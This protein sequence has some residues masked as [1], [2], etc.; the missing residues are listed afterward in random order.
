MNEFF[1][2]HGE[3]RTTVLRTFSRRRGSTT[4]LRRILRVVGGSV[5]LG[6]VGFGIFSLVYVHSVSCEFEG[7]PC[8]ESEVLT[9]KQA[10]GKWMFSSYP[11]SVQGKKATVTREF[12]GILHV[13]LDRQET[14]MIVRTSLEGNDGAIVRRDGSLENTKISTDQTATGEAI[15]YDLDISTDS[16]GGRVGANRL[17]VYDALNDFGKKV[18]ITRVV[19]HSNDEIEIHTA[20][21]LT[22]VL[23]SERIA[24]QLRS[25]Q[26]IL[27]SPTIEGKPA[28]VDMRFTRPI[29][30]YL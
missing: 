5:L 24:D 29:L 11:T 20:R 7:N 21:D 9:F 4:S 12:P 28:R 23:S 13:R 6:I 27:S 1:L 18:G 10:Q 2:S 17:A 19:V 22:A 16:N 3:K 26:S 15:F 30:Q 8:T 14:L 25:L